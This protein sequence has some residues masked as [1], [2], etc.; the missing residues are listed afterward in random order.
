MS[1]RAGATRAVAAFGPD[2]F[3]EAWGSGWGVGVAFSPLSPWRSKSIVV[4]N[5]VIRGRKESGDAVNCHSSLIRPGVHASPDI[6]NRSCQGTSKKRRR[7]VVFSKTGVH[8]RGLRNIFGQD[9]HKKAT[10]FEAATLTRP[11]PL[12]TLEIS[13]MQMLLRETAPPK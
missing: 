2:G 13:R 5:Y 10:I 7:R 9:R 6:L 12:L 8:V 3:S 1:R 11:L 4:R